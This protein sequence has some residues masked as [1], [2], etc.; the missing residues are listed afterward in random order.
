MVTVFLVA[1]GILAVFMTCVFLIG[2]AKQ[3]NSIVD[4]AWGIGFILI[5]LYAFFSTGT[6]LARQI[7]VTTLV[8]VWGVR[9]SV[10][11]FI[12]NWGK[13][14]DHRYQAF[15]MSWRPYFVLKS[16]FY[17]FML[18]GFLIWVIDYPVIFT[19]ASTAMPP[20]GVLDVVG[21]VIWL[22]GFAFEA[23]GDYQLKKF[24]DNPAN[25]GKICKV[26]LWRYTRHPNYFGE[27]TMWW[28]IFLIVLSVPWG[29]TGVISPLTVTYLL[30]FV[31]GV[32]MAER[33]FEKNEEY[34]Q[35]KKETSA[36]IPWFP[37][38]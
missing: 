27:V 14:E 9:I 24:I 29:W 36:L 37:R 28:G 19:N 12:R 25:T 18:Q 20:L 30:M 11:I 17:I 15:R 5:T 16:F 2:L 3:D 1:G 7:L 21:M 33:I 31:S 23:I 10:H 6:Y 35:Y 26:G 22:I 8:V 34:A 4:V 38:I 13:E 32:P